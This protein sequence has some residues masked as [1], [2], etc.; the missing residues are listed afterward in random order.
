MDISDP[1]CLDCGYRLRGL[2]SHRCPECGREFNPHNPFTMRV[3]RNR[4]RKRRTYGEVMN[5][6]AIS[7]L[8]FQVIP[9]LLQS[10]PG[11]NAAVSLLLWLAVL[12]GWIWWSFFR[13]PVA[14]SIGW[15]RLPRGPRWKSVVIIAFFINCAWLSPFYE[16]C[17]H[18]EYFWIGPMGLVWSDNGM[19]PCRDFAPNGSTY[20]GHNWYYVFEMGKFE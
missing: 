8:A 16:S 5:L 10:R 20:L 15:R 4:R 3:R 13:N 2:E 17:P 19:G 1:R 11:L 18:G 14:R 7:A 12:V 6:L 9:R